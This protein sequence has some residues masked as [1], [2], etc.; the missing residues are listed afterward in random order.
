MALLAVEKRRIKKGNFNYQS[1]TRQAVLILRNF[2]GFV[3][4]VDGRI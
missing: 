2:N 4:Y 1:A 3:V